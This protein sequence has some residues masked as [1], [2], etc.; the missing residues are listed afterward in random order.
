MARSLHLACFLITTLAAAWILLGDTLLVPAFRWRLVATTAHAALVARLLAWTGWTSLP[1][2]A[3]PAAIAATIVVVMGTA[4]L[5]RPRV[6]R[7]APSVHVDLSPGAQPTRTVA[8]PALSLPDR[9]EWIQCYNPATM[10]FLGEVAV[11]SPDDVRRIVA[12]ARALQPAWAAT[13]FEE[14][15]RVLR[16]MKAAVLAQQD[17]IVRLSCIDTGKPRV[18]A[19]FGEVMSTLGKLDWLIAAGEQALAP[20][21]RATNFTSMHKRARVEYSPLGVIGEGRG[22]GSPLVERVGL[23]M[24]ENIDEFS[25]RS[26]H[27]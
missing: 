24:W 20:Q 6:L 2:A 26:S 27:C 7:A 22:Q 9:R 5:L 4:L 3:S 15:R 11:S 23:S 21:A 8:T 10:A 14:R 17:D 16:T 12:R 13:S 25:Y 18:D 1:A 19:L